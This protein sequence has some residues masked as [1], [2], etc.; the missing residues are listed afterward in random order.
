MD[1]ID[2]I[3][4]RY[5]VRRYKPDPIEDEKLSA[6][7]NSARMAPTACNRQPF[8]IILVHSRSREEELL[9][10]YSSPWFVQAPF[11]LCV[12]GLPDTAWV[13]KDGKSYMYVDLAIVMDHI[14]LAATDLGLGTCIIAAFNEFNAR[15]VLS[16]P[17]DVEPVLFT[18]LGYPAEPP[19]TKERKEL[20]DLVDYE[21]WKGV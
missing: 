20:V 14:V 21:H 8:K 11:V 15:K 2:V 3:S 5:S 9:S 4:N 16:L 19:R 1:V 13:R 7:L 12:C 10:I 6:I 17:Q 18:P